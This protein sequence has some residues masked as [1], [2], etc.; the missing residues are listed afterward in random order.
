MNIMTHRGLDPALN[1]YFMESSR[2]AFVD[3]LE[4]GFG[5]EFDI[6][7]TK[8][9][10]MIVI[11]DP[12]LSRITLGKDNRS[13]IDVVSQE[14]LSMDF[15]GCHLISVLDL[16]DLIAKSRVQLSA[17]HL[18]YIWQKSEYL[19]KLL[20][21]LEKIDT[22]RLIIFD[23][24]VKTAQYMKE[25]NNKLHIAPS[26]SHPYD[27]ERYNNAVGGTLMT[28]EEVIQNKN[29]FDWVWLDEW[30]RSLPYGSDSSTRAKHGT[31]QS[32][33][34]YNKENFNL[35]QK[36]GFRIAL[37][38]PEL[39]ATSPGLLGGETHEDARDHES[40]VKR[41]KE[42]TALIPDAVCTDWPDLVRSMI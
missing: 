15:S 33:T 42:I 21:E 31:G 7:F 6:Q 10:Q 16:F 36:S 28:I 37:V 18:K 13:I 12:N 3:Q 14:I 9:G 17:L 1:P 11:H 38:T 24:T 2:E 25:I 32:K 34:L 19:N 5:L 20:I 41:I 40:L 23:V 35:L 30:D 22:E 39:H 4:R 27:I 26:V 8:D 29:L